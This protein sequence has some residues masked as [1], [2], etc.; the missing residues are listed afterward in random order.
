MDAF[1]FTVEKLT[2][3]K[4]PEGKARIRC[5]DTRVRCLTFRVNSG[6]SKVFSYYRRLPDDNESPRKVCEITIGSFH[7]VG[8]D[9]A[10]R[11][12]DELN[13]LVGL[14]KD[15]SLNHV[16]QHLTYDALFQRYLEEYAKTRT[17]TWQGAI[18]NHE[19]Y[20]KR[21]HNRSIADIDRES[22]QHWVN[23]NGEEFGHY[24][25][26][27]TYSTM[28]AVFSWALRKD[29]ING[30][31]PC[32]G[33]DVF[34]TRARERFIQPGVEFQKFA[35]ALNEEPNETVRDF[36]WM[37]LFTGARRANV[38]AMEWGQVDFELMLWRIPITK[39][40]ESLTV[41]L[42]LAAMEILRRHKADPKAHDRWVFPSD[43]SGKKT[44]VLGHLISP[45]KAWGRILERAKI[46]DLRIHDLRRTAGS[47]M[48]SSTRG[49]L[50][51]WIQSQSSSALCPCVTRV[52]DSARAA[53]KQ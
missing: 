9:E 48:A 4:C 31:N 2:N 24:T 39:N 35:K 53:G 38:L 41:P 32:L 1:N 19:R 33:V 20:L 34:K 28:R 18:Y 25:A 36:F 11:R 15:P 8:L 7:D 5:Q 50:N 30:G 45:H 14:K 49:R 51:E 23:D 13:V 6:G 37:C 44:G 27:R 10:R 3:L 52:I 29:I 40:Q 22:V 46:E 21:W 17:S 43:R 16:Q 47:Y 42:T 26:N 12:A